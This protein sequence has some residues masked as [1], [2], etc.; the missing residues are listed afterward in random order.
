M[1]PNEYIDKLIR[2]IQSCKTI[3]HLISSKKCV[4]L[5]DYR[6]NLHYS[7]FNRNK[8]ISP[9]IH[10]MGKYNHL[11]AMYVLKRELSTKKIEL[12]IQEKLRLNNEK[13]KRN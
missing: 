3:D 9:N 10:S 1:N 2:I 11:M 13:N 12:Q 4:N 7:F 8:N 6:E 5:F